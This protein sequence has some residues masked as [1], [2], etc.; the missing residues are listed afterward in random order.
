MTPKD[1]QSRGNTV[2]S[3]LPWLS[4]HLSETGSYSWSELQRRTMSCWG[5]WSLQP[6][7]HLLDARSK[8][9]SSPTPRARSSDD[10]PS[11]LAQHGICT[12]GENMQQDEKFKFKPDMGDRKYFIPARW[13]QIKNIVW[14]EFWILCLKKCKNKSHCDIYMHVIYASVPSTDAALLYRH[15]YHFIKERVFILQ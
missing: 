2:K 14:E 3:Y 10:C 7:Q 4:H 6:G 12:E 11:V 8:W 5:T 15:N 9:G 1:P 13:R